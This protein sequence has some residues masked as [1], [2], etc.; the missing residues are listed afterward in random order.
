MTNKYVE[1]FRKD[2]EKLLVESGHKDLIDL[3]EASEEYLMEK[4][5]EK[6]NKDLAEGKAKLYINEE[7]KKHIQDAIKDTWKITS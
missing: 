1:Q 4:L 5:V 3:N 2:T 6:N 7:V